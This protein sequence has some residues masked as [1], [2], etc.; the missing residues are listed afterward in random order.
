MSRAAGV[1]AKL[2]SMSLAADARKAVRL[3]RSAIRTRSA[4]GSAERTQRERGPL[5]SGHFQIAVYFADGPV[6]LYQLRQWYAPLIELSKTWPVLIIARTGTGAEALFAES[7][8]PV[9]YARSIDEIE[10]V[11]ADQPLRVVL[12]VN[13]NTRNFQMFRYG[14]RWHVF[15]SHGESDKV[16]MQS[17]QIRSYNYAFVAGDAAMARLR[18][19][20]WDYDVD[21]RAIPIG[22]PQVDHFG[23]AAP[24][25]PADERTVIFYAPT[26]EGDRSSM[27]Y[28]SIITHGEAIAGAVL[29]DDRLRLV[30]RPH[31]RSGVYN[32]AYGAAH[33]RIVA[34]IEKAN[35]E[36]PAARHVYDVSP[37]IDWQLS[38]T[39]I[40]VMDVSAMVYD[41]LA[42][43]KPLLVT[44]PVNPLTT[45]DE[46]GYLAA[47]DWLEA[48]S[49]GRVEDL[50][51]IADDPD[52]VARLSHWSRQYFG[53]TAAGASTARFHAGIEHL[54]QEWERWNA[55]TAPLV[56]ADHDDDEDLERDFEA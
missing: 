13:Q 28:G 26:W 23:D 48:T 19:A 51:A 15:I 40:A 29:A 46:R 45:V 42:V 8:L 30:Y 2:E 35:A 17:N 3:I 6:N 14:H 20:L 34:A 16:Y 12:Y 11:L 25:Y 1:L 39:D 49:A 27:E 41:R 24:P 10:S 18:A 53:D 32:P 36:D 9:H 43:G 50:V 21:R 31:P 7:P 56:V 54:M 55:T 38:T 5:K 52:V 4:I 33:R 37:T 47:C 22:R 44:R